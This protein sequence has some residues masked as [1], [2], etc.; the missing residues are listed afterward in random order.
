MSAEVGVAPCFHA[1]A[2]I[3]GMLLVDIDVASFTRP[4]AVRARLRQGMAE[5]SIALHQRPDVREVFAVIWTGT[6]LAGRREMNLATAAAEGVHRRVEMLRGTPLAVAVVFADD[7]VSAE[8]V[9]QR[10]RLS[11]RTVP[12]GVS[13]M[14]WPD[15]CAYGVHACAAAYRL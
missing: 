8:R 4:R 2:P 6:H 7:Q 9:R 1:E 12:D 10:L 11:A 3:R 5:L 14:T 13:A 15:V